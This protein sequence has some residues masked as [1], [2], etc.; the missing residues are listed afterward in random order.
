VIE[1]DAGEVREEKKW[2]RLRVGGKREAFRRLFLVECVFADEETL[3]CD[4]DKFDVE[5]ER[6]D[7]EEEDRVLTV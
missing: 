4:L 5:E 1:D 6:V 7:A 3:R 2:N